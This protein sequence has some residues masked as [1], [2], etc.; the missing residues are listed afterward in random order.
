MKD[1][2]LDDALSKKEIVTEGKPWVQN[3]SVNFII[4]IHILRAE[5]ENMVSTEGHN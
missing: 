5:G 4:N 1:F 3:Y 2:M